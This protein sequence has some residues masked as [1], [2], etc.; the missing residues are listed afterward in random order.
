MNASRKRAPRAL[1][2]ALLVL[3]VAIVAGL[4]L[5]S[6]GGA[7]DGEF[8]GTPLEPGTTFHGAKSKTGRL[9][10]TDPSLLGRTDSTLVDVAVKLD[11]DPVAAYTGGIAGLAPTSPE[12]TGLDLADN[13]AAVQA[14]E[15]YAA[16]YEQSVKADIQSEVSG[17]TIGQSF[18]VAYGGI[19][20]QLPANQI[21]DLLSVSGVAAVQLDRLEK[22]LTDAS[23]KFVGATQVWPQLGGQT[24][25]GEG[26]KVGVLDT[27]IWPEH[28]SFADNA[29]L[30]HPG[31]TYGCEFGNGTNPDLGDPFTCN[32]K[33][34]GAYAKLNT[35]T[36]NV[37]TLAGEFCAN[38]G[39]ATGSPKQCS[40][41]DADGHGT[42]TSSTA[43]GDKVDSAVLLGVE[44]GPISGMAPGAHVIMYRV[45]MTQGCFTTDS[46]AAVNQAIADGVNVINF[47]ISGGNN[48]FTDP[49]ELAFRDAYEAGII[50]NASAGNSGPGA[51]TS[52]HAGPWTNTVGAS[53]S[54]RHFLST[55]HLTADGG[56]TLDLQGVTVTAGMSSPTDVVLASAAPY[57]SSL[58]LT[59]ATPGTFTGKVVVCERGT[60]GRA[61]KGYNVLQGG[62][63]GYIL[64]NQSAAVT[65][66]ETDNHWLPAIHVQ[67][68]SNAVASFVSTHTGVKATWASG[69]ASPVT[70]DVMASFSSRGPIG[71]F[72]KPDVT[73]VGVQVLAGHSPQ[74]LGIAGGPA[75]ELYQA[76]A[77]TS[78]S[79]PHSAGVSA[80]VKASH[81]DWTPGQIKS[82]LMTSSVQS[83]LK[84]DGAT[85]ADPFDR[86]AGSVR[87]N[88]AVSPTVTFDVPS[89]DYFAAGTDPLGRVNLNLPSI[90]Y[91]TF[92]GSAT[93]TRTFRNVSGS[94]QPMKVETQ[95]PAGATITVTPKNLDVDPGATQTLTIAIDGTTLAD[96]QYFGQIKLVPT[97]KGFNPVVIPVAFFKKQG[98]VT[99]D[100]SCSPTT[101]KVNATSA[102]QV[103]IQN[104]ASVNANA[105]LS[106]QGPSNG[107]LT[108]QN[109]SPPGVP[110]G[111]GFTWSGTLVGAQ[112][113]TINS[114]T[115][116]TG[117]AGGYLGLAG[118]G[119]APFA[120]Q[121]DDTL[122]N[123]NVPT[124]YYGGEPY[125][126]IGV[127]SNGYVVIGGGTGPDNQVFPQTFPNTA[128]P[129]NVVAGLWTDLLPSAAGGAGGIRIATLT[130]GGQTWLVVDWGGVRNFSNATTHTFEMWFRLASGAAGT[131]PGSEQVTLTYG[132]ANTASPDPGTGGNS[133]AENRVGTS[134]Q[135]LPTPAN[136]TEWRVNTTAPAAGE[137]K[138]F[139]Y[140][141][142]GRN[143]GVFDI[144]ASLT[145]NLSN[146]TTKKVVTITVN[147]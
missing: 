138:T 52:N 55:L 8:T 142:L 42:H 17:E 45:C 44:R 76:I 81:P 65:D 107:K 118:F 93:T 95:A 125:T 48:A 21:G 104:N 37:A 5:A 68:E 126:Q 41:R 136:N 94:Q 135:N 124:F 85:A 120:G 103:T 89:S 92:S 35:Y 40:A 109:V 139:T 117:P 114:I 14:Y 80:L 56:A 46:V 33:L 59:P 62:A 123:F 78:M 146:S 19:A 134:G 15:S 25:A 13:Q 36:A 75:G 86:G 108:I 26:I 141:A 128:R 16:D 110:S 22:P 7:A 60:N 73:S 116:T 30:S 82:A 115:P 133:G 29:G 32:N 98:S 145:S 54:D 18:R 11:Y 96:G 102:C 64:Y 100:H 79:S 38:P 1:R 43:A 147:K 113:P 9:A 74:H 88:R 67:Y 31:G 97:K 58:C 4:T 132:T 87:A 106:V 23:P 84:E 47:S 66:V 72:I 28:P 112:P 53:T 50:V 6:V 57:S 20:M 34:I 2:L 24:K 3:G 70:G 127:D 121:G 91:T 101:I 143:T 140:D 137:S 10:Q 51:G 131:G 63:A 99:L 130:G 77:G 83:V 119:I 105:S 129:N 90:N 122:T 39:P 27:G 12:V 144:V 111:N 71:D 61:E 69:T 49:V